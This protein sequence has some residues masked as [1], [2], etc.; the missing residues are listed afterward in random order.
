MD[1]DYTGHMRWRQENPG[2][3]DSE[4]FHLV[5]D[6]PEA[7]KPV[8]SVAD[9]LRELEV[10]RTKSEPVSS[11]ELNL[12]SGFSASELCLLPTAAI[13]HFSLLSE[14]SKLSP[15]L[16]SELCLLNTEQL[17]QLGTF[18]LLQ[19]APVSS[20]ELSPAQQARRDGRLTK[21]S[22]ERRKE[23]ATKAAK[24][25][26]AARRAKKLPPGFVHD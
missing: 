25:S 26:A 18:S 6:E 4:Y 12:L 19:T 5:A 9:Y 24:A 21:I 2:A 15:T 10:A 11:S 20:S 7:P 3:P 14:L 23:I 22:P 13:I 8:Q 1:Y 17:K 16:L